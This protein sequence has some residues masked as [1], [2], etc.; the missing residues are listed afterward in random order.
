MLHVLPIDVWRVR[1]SYAYLFERG[2]NTVWAPA[3]FHLARDTIKLVIGAGAL[4][5]P[6]IQTATLLW[7]LVIAA[8]RYLMFAI[9]F[10]FTGEVQVGIG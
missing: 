5:D 2:R 6:A 1:N 7:L 9:P 4:A 10:R 8:V 3:G